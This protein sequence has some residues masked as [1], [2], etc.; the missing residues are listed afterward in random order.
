MNLCDIY[1]ELK[2]LNKKTCV[3]PDKISA[4]F[5]SEFKFVLS[6]LLQLLFDKYSQTSIFPDK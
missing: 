5:F 2:R 3:G 6:I 4:I 1:E